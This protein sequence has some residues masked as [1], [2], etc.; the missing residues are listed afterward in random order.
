MARDITSERKILVVV[1][2]T[3]Q[4]SI[5]EENV[6][7]H[8]E[9]CKF[10]FAA[11]GSEGTSK[12]ENDPPH[13]VIVEG[14][15][16]VVKTEKFVKWIIEENRQHPMAVLW[17]MPIPEKDLFVDYV[18]TGQVQY[19]PDSGDE[20]RLSKVLSRAMN[21]LSSENHH[22]DFVL[23]FLSPGDVLIKEGENSRSVYLVKSGQ[24]QAVH[25]KEDRVTVLG[26]IL[27]GEF[28]GEMAYINGEP[29]SADVVALSDCELIE[30]GVDR[31][32]SLLFK[33]PSWSKAL[34]K[35]LS[36]R[37]RRANEAI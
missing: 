22:D 18:V 6:K 14:N 9:Y 17:L 30:F 5:I 10:Y 21:F 15:L 8:I 24:L 19:V 29:R 7:Q 36:K 2:D 4:W 12:I 16:P 37:L 20:S 11:S 3:K 23:K 33:K 28:V 25:K 34:M 1:S 13:L 31:L 27:E 26:Q 35:T 32:D